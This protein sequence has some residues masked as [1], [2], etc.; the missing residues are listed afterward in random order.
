MYICIF[1]IGR[2]SVFVFGFL[3]S[4]LSS[5][6]NKNARIETVSMVSMGLF[7]LYLQRGVS[8]Q[9][10]VFF[11]GKVLILTS[12]KKLSRKVKRS[13]MFVCGQNKV[14]N[15]L[16][17]IA[18]LSTIETIVIYNLFEYNVKTSDISSLNEHFFYPHKC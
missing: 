15:N 3:G 17:D 1:C 11:P 9:V 16:M 8:F 7:K 5:S 2:Y 4:W 6:Y 18:L 10:D 13:I 12:I 14:E